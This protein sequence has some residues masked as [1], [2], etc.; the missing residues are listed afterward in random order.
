MVKIA[1]TKKHKQ[2]KPFLNEPLMITDYEDIFNSM[3]MIDSENKIK[4]NYLR[5]D[6]RQNY[7]TQV[8]SSFLKDKL[9]CKV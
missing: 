7:R 4:F 6:D 3:K 1:I 9:F 8:S 5:P 2:V